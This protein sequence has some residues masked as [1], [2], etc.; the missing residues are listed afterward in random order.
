MVD[1]ESSREDVRDSKG[2]FVHPNVW[3]PLGSKGGWSSLLLPLS[4]LLSAF[5][6]GFTMLEERQE[7]VGWSSNIPLAETLPPPLW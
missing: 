6:D 7:M 3:S 4:P 5:L 2:I 1:Y